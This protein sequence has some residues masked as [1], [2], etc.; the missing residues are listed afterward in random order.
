MLGDDEQTV[1]PISIRFADLGHGE[2]RPGA[3]LDHIT[4]HIHILEMNAGS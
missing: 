2:R 4:Y 1:A 3:L